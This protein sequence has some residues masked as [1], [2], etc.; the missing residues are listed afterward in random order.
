VGRSDGQLQD[1]PLVG[2]KDDPERLIALAPDLVLIR[3]MISRGYPRLV[4]RLKQVGIEVISLQPRGMEELF[5][6]WRTL[7]AI[8]D[9]TAEAEQMVERFQQ[10]LAELDRQVARIPDTERKKVYFEAIHAR[11]KT[12]A[13]DSIAAFVLR[14]AG[15]ENVALDAPVVRQTNIAA[16]G[17]E[18]LL[19]QGAKIDVFLAQQGRM[20]PIEQADILDEPGFQA[21]KAVQQRAVYLVPEHLV[22]RPTMELLDGMRLIHELLYVKQQGAEQ[23]P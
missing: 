10:G 1:R 22:A 6:Y 14:S 19:A 21:I 8:I 3:P 9:R 18:R 13:P 16:Y 5:E 20:N 2:L 4:E 17:K 11:M 12:F 15:G 23:Q 7:G